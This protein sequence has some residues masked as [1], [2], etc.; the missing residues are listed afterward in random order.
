[1]RLAYRYPAG[2][3]LETG[4]CQLFQHI[5]LRC[6]EAQPVFVFDT[7]PAAAV[8][9]PESPVRRQPFMRCFVGL[10]LVGGVIDDEQVLEVVGENAPLRAR[11]TGCAM[12]VGM[13]ER[14]DMV[15]IDIGS[16]GECPAGIRTDPQSGFD[17][18]L[19][20]ILELNRRPAGCNEQLLA[21]VA[22]VFIGIDPV[23]P[24]LALIRRV[25]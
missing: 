10:R 15:D 11:P 22:A 23:R 16:P 18:A 13:R 5:T 2:F 21:S 12:P 24:I 9:A 14:H 17:C 19:P 3:L 4:V 20:G 6:A 8:F 1:M 25:G 7:L